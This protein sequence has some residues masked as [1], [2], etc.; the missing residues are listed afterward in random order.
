MNVQGDGPSTVVLGQAKPLVPGYLITPFGWAAQPLAALVQADPELLTHVFELDR[1]RMHVI[2]LALAHLNGNTAPHLAPVLFRASIHEVLHRVVGRSPPGIRRV[3]R[4]LP[5]AVLSRKAYLSL[6]E[7]LVDPRSAKLLH[8]LDKTEITDAT[9]RVL[10]DIP[11]ALRPVLA[12]LVRF[13]EK[14][15]RLEHLPDGLR[16]LTSRGAAK[17]F[18]AL[19]A[20]LA[21]Q[22]QP[23]QFIA[24][25][26]KLVSELPLP[27]TL[28]TMQI[29]QAR[30]VD[31]TADICALAKRFKNCL[32]NFVTQ[33]DAGGCA[34]YLWD[35]PAAPAVCLVTRQGRLGWSLS[36]ALGPE[37]EKLDREQLQKI[38]TAFAEA[39]IPQYSAIRS[40]EYILVPDPTMPRTRR[41]RRQALEQR[42]WELEEAAWVQDVV[43]VID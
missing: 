20:D 24:R 14:I 38:T 5:F 30:R 15:E 35:D 22:A 21:T 19:I 10:H 6:I 18:D 9:V 28:P 36:V 12:R 17:S 8:H 27:Q 31:A 41:Q 32:E 42:L 29:G 11:A 33:I 4:R 7:L 1:M 39:G 25:L 34:V 26:N 2:A 16:W 40:L 43:D 37:N 3:L 23:G 13:I